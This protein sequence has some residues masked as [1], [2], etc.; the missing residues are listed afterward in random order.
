MAIGVSDISVQFQQ[1]WQE[2]SRWPDAGE[3]HGG[4]A[5]QYS[6]SEQLESGSR[7]DIYAGI[8][9]RVSFCLDSDGRIEARRINE[10]FEEKVS[11]LREEGD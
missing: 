10:A 8:A 2:T 11:A 3:V 6:Q 1:H 9:G 7:R 4:R 5:M